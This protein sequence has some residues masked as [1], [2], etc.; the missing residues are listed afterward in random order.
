[1]YFAEHSVRNSGK[2]GPY[3]GRS[4]LKLQILG[5]VGAYEN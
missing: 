5:N 1:M 4:H 2:T 3:I